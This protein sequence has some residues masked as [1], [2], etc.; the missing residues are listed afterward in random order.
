MQDL[1]IAG[2]DT[3]ATTLAW[4]MAELMKNPEVRYKL[5]EELDAVG[6]DRLVRESDLS[7]LKYLQAVVKENFRL[8][9]IIPLLVPHESHEATK[10]AGYDIPNKTRV[11]FNLFGMGRDSKV[12]EDPLRFNPDRFLHSKVDLKGNDFKL[13]PLVTLMLVTVIV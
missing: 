4:L 9:P 10:V 2:S 12:W 5:T 13:L 6:R 3:K 1:L 7:Q 11:F 8:H